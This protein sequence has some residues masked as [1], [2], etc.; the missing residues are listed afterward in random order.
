MAAPVILTDQSAPEGRTHQAYFFQ[1]AA[2]NGPTSW[3]TAGTTLPPG[4]T[5]NTAN[6]RISG[7]P[8]T[9]GTGIFALQAT[10]GDGTSSAVT[11]AMHVEATPPMPPGG[12]FGVAIDLGTGL[13][14]YDGVEKLTITSADDLLQQVRLVRNGIVVPDID[15]VSLRFAID[16]VERDLPVVVGTQFVAVGTGEARVYRHAT[17]L[18][19]DALSRALDRGA[20][21]VKIKETAAT[22]LEKRIARFLGIAEFE[23][24][25]TNTGAATVGRNPAVWTSRPFE[26]AVVRELLANV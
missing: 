22:A 15:L 18:T 1:P 9:A 2:M 26:V 21:R 12:F 11:F 5:L 17:T 25:Y 10:N 8:T 7:I 4:L 14:T 13:V 24:R 3:T 19:S 23:L 16:F 20:Q 6:G